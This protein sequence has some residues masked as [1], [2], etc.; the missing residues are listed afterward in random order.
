MDHQ[1]HGI[2]HSAVLHN[3]ICSFFEKINKGEKSIYVIKHTFES[4]LLLP[5]VKTSSPPPHETTAKKSFSSGSHVLWLQLVLVTVRFTG[6]LSQFG[7][8]IADGWVGP[9]DLKITWRN[10]GP[11]PFDSFHVSQVL[12]ES[13]FAS[14]LWNTCDLTAL[15]KLR[16]AWAATWKHFTDPRVI[17]FQVICFLFCQNQHY[18]SEPHPSPPP[19]VISL[20]HYRFRIQRSRLIRVCSL[21]VHFWD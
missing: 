8:P 13:T 17:Y 6:H 9:T 2:F 18:F 21:E 7:L 11:I 14:T 3:C 5:P 10:R 1:L 19:P 15:W 20:E 4:K 16:G 12:F